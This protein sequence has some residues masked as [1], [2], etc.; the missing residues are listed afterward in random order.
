MKIASPRRIASEISHQPMRSGDPHTPF[1]HSPAGMGCPIRSQRMNRTRPQPSRVLSLRRCT[2]LMKAAINTRAV[3]ATGNS[4]HS[5]TMA[6]SRAASRQAR[7][8]RPRKQWFATGTRSMPKE[9]ATARFSCVN[10]SLMM[11]SLK[12]SSSSAPAHR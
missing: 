9:G 7:R 12:S 11:W 6:R 10:S 2:A 3:V 4:T 8:R 1:T 5:T